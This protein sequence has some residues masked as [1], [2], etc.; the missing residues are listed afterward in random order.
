M[1]CAISGEAPREPVVSIK[2]GLLFEKSLILKHIADCGT[3]PE[4]NEP[5]TVDDLISVKSASKVIKPR[6]PVATSIPTLLLTLQNEWDSVM[7]ETHQLKQHYH[8]TRLELANALYEYDAAKRVIARLIKERDDARSTLSQFKASHGTSQSNGHAVA[9]DNT[10]ADVDMAPVTESALPEAMVQTINKTSEELSQTRRKRKAPETLATIEEIASMTEIAENT[11]IHTAK[12]PTSLSLDLFT[13]DIDGNSIS[14]ALLAGK[15][16]SVYILDASNKCESEISHAKAHS[17]PVTCAVWRGASKK[18]FITTSI[19]HTVKLWN[20]DRV[21]N[22][23]K[24][25]SAIVFD[26]HKDRATMVS[27]H[28]SGEFAISVG[29][30]SIWAIL[31]LDSGK[32]VA[33]VSHPE[34]TSGYT[35]V[36]FHPDGFLLGTGTND[37]LI[38]LWDTKTLTK[39]HTFTGHLDGTI[40]SIAFSENGYYL[41]STSDKETCVRFWD[42]RKLTNFYTLELGP[43]EGVTGI[44]R[45]RFDHSGQYVGICV[46]NELRIHLVKK[47]DHVATFTNNGASLTDFAF[48]VDAKYVVMVG[49]ERKLSF[50]SNA[51]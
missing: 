40:T 46:G 42:L 32:I 26:A 51:E 12:E 1:F 44:A 47:W 15:D 11:S 22:S 34:I 7:L 38:H 28:P 37:S 45:V 27:V 49:Q 20:V 24:I 2:S 14:W 19:D 41:A 23:Y 5:L 31:D 6:P 33:S 18:S 17:K 36:Q 50:F 8:S 25:K 3:D 16:G 30:D 39:A 43:I 9:S 10:T 29:M 21:K 4:N 35:T 13:A 48:G